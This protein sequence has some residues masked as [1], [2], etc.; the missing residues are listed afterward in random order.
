[1]RGCKPLNYL[2]STRPLRRQAPNPTLL[3]PPFPALW[4]PWWP[5]VLRTLVEPL[6]VNS[7]TL[8]PDHR[9]NQTYSKKNWSHPK[10]HSLTL[11]LAREGIVKVIVDCFCSRKKISVPLH[12]NRLASFAYGAEARRSPFLCKIV[13]LS[14]SEQ[15]VEL[16]AL[17]LPRDLSSQPVAP[18]L[19]A[20]AT[21]RCRLRVQVRSNFSAQGCCTY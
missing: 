5:S 2:E 20:R 8:R 21:V 18:S 19:A 12:Q 1:M 13:G 16:G 15:L 11:Q 9:K 3:V 7:P 4:H 6:S 14:V 10:P 17:P